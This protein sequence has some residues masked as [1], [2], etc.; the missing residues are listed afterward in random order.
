PPRG[1]KTQLSSDS[2]KAALS[3]VVPY[4]PAVQQKG[5]LPIGNRPSFEMVVCSGRNDGLHLLGS[6]RVARRK[7]LE[8]FAGELDHRFAQLRAFWRDAVQIGVCE[9]APHTGEE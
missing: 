3:G 2:V 7:R 4:G 1:G 5:R 8:D 6:H 9:I